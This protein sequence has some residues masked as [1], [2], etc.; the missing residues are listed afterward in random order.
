MNK[1]LGFLLIL[2]FLFACGRTEK[3]SEQPL[4]LADFYFF[5]LKDG[6]EV[7]LSGEEFTQGQV[8]KV[9]IFVENF[10]YTKTQQGYKIS[11]MEL[12]K[13]IDSEGSIV[14][15]KVEVDQTRVLK[16]L[17][18]NLIFINTLGFSKRMPAGDY[19]LV[20]EI[21]DRIK[22]QKLKIKKKIHVKALI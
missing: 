10:G 4:K 6:K 9:K 8:V 3:K 11:V 13:I 22:G 17:S 1:K 7:K 18:Q 21:V 14:Y 16:E 12:L 2:L 5:V 15:S 19:T 20:F